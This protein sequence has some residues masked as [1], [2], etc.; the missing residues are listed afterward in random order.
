MTECLQT[1][2]TLGMWRDAENVLRRDIVL[3]FTQK[4]YLSSQAWDWKLLKVP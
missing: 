4:V 2:D 1:Y 3:P